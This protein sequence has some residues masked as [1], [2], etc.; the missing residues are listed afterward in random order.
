MIGMLCRVFSVDV[1]IQQ[2]FPDSSRASRFTNRKNP[3]VL[4]SARG[5]SAHRKNA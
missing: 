2:F 1:S 4:S 3:F 5:K